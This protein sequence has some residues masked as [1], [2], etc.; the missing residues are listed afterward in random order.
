MKKQLALVLAA[1]MVS[2]SLAA[3]GSSGGAAETTA[4]PAATEAPA[5]TEA[6]ETEAA[7]TEAAETEAAEAA[8]EAPD[9]AALVSDAFIDPV[10]DWAKYDELIAEIKAET[11]MAH[12]TE[13]M[14][15]AEDIL[16][17]NYAVIPVYYYNDLYME[18]DYVKGVY[19]NAFATKFFMYAELE[20]G[21]DTLRL[22]LASEP[23]YLDP[24]LNSSVDGACLAANSFSGLYT[25][26]S[27]GKPVPACA[28][29]YEVSEDG[30]TYT[31]KLKEGLKWSDG[32]DLTANDFVY[33]WKRA[34]DPKTA[35]DYEYMFSGFDGYGDGNINVTAIDD[36]T[37]EFVLAAPCA[38]MEDLMAFP[39][40]Y[41]VKQEAVESYADWETTPGGWCQEAGFVSNGAYVCTGWNH[42][43]SM[44]YEKN[45]YFWDADNVKIEKLE[46]MLSADDT[47]IY[48]AYNAGDV[49]FID[50][51]PTD[52]VQTLIDSQNPEFK[53]IDELGTYYIAFNVNSKLFEGK[54]PE[55]AA[56]MREAINLL[57]DRDYIVENIG[58]TGQVI[59][60]SYIPLGMMDGNGGIFKDDPAVGYYDAYAINNDYEGTIAKATELMKA[61]G[62][63]FDE[64]GTLSDATPL[65]IEYLT[66]ESSGHV[67]IAESLQQDLDAIGIKIS[68]Q[69]Q[70][71][72]VFLEER[73]N[74]NFD[75]AREGW[76]ADFNDPINM[77]EMFTTTSGNND[78]QYGRK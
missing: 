56:C 12:R 74:G 46:F 28:E 76:I 69:V 41:P 18:K 38:Y 35:A 26:D 22:N 45:P 33:S 20:N 3:C 9:A 39:T 57:I 17:S 60:T 75:M 58:Q 31:V 4:A 34:T 49:D 43:T 59:A 62:F 67:A 1:V 66:N 14:H 30:L 36:T 29:S 65:E 25:Y 27:E 21:S 52:E 40:F 5:E 13:L 2:A 24:A 15:Q 23:D 47:A 70:D 78:P 71:W 6:A 77:L 64:D 63:E 55:Q 53:I 11:D 37:L 44:T 68:I 61:A 7:E 51:V 73:K 42:D 72:N 32:S 50:T 54:T 19:A 48:S 10:N 8:E 16:M